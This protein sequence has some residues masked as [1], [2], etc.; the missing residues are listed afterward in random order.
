[1]SQKEI[2]SIDLQIKQLQARKQKAKAKI[3][4][5]KRKD[6]TRRKI[7]VGAAILKKVGSGEWPREKMMAMLEGELTKNGDRALFGLD[8]LPESGTET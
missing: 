4:T 5:Q 3:T 2:D 8:P 6:D 1:M 7:L